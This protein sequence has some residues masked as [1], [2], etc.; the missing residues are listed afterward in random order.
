[1]DLGAMTMP[2]ALLSWDRSPILIG[3]RSF[4]PA[5]FQVQFRIENGMRCGAVLERNIWTRENPVFAP[6]LS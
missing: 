5:V 2:L 6:K 1:M 3:S 4:L